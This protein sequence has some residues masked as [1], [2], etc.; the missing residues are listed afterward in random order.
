MRMWKKVLAAGVSAVMIFPAATGAAV[1]NGEVHA[2]KQASEQVPITA[3]A[4]EKNK[5]AYKKLKEM[6]EL[7]DTDT[8]VIKYSKPLGKSVHKK[9]G[10]T[11]VRSL[12]QLGYDVVRVPKSKKVSE[13]VKV[14]RQQKGVSSI[15]PSVKYKQFAAQGDPKKSKMHHLPMLNID[16]SLKLAGKHKV[17]VAVVDGGV[18][19]KHPDLQ[20]QLLP[21]YNAANPASNPIR[22]MHGTHVAGIIASKANN[23]IGGHGVNP[24]AKILPVDVFNGKMSANDFTI[25]EGILYAV[26]KGAD[27][28]N[29]SL[30]G[31]ASSPLVEEAVR[32]AIDSGVVVVAAAGNEATD[33]YS[34]PAAYPGVISVGNIDRN[35]KLS[36]SSNFGPSV[37][38]VAPGE[39]IYNTGYEKDGK[40]SSFASLTGTSMAAPMV[41][42]VASLLKSKYPQLTAYDIENILERTA[43]DL[44]AK[45]YDTKY[46]NG[47]VNP[48]AAL[49][50][51]IKKLPKQP[52]LTGDTLIRSA[53]PLKAGKNTLKGQIKT[54]GETHWFKVDLNENE[55]VQTI[56]EGSSDYDYGMDFYFIPE[57]A[58]SEEGMLME[59]NKG[60]AGEQEGSLFTAEEKGT[61]VIGVKD[62]NGN[63]NASGLSAYTFT[64][65]KITGLKADPD[66]S[67]NPVKITSLPYKKGDFTLFPQEAGAPD[68]DH[69]TIAVDE[70]KVVS[71]SLSALPGVNSAM[72]LSVVTQDEKERTEEIVAEADDHGSSQGES[73]SFKAVP[74][75]EYKLV[76]TNEAF[77][78]ME[79]MG[80]LLDM[81]TMNPGDMEFGDYTASAYPYELKVEEKQLPED[82][83]G[84]P[85]KEDLETALEEGSLSPDKYAEAKAAAA[86][87]GTID[88]EEPSEEMDDA[89]TKA[90]LANA[91]PYT[92]GKELSGY[93]QVEA[94]EDYYSFTPAQNGVYEFDVQ[95]GS[96]QFPVVSILQHDKETGELIPISGGEDDM[97][98]SIMAMLGGKQTSQTT[99]ALKKGETYI[100][101]LANEMYNISADPYTLRS[102]KVADTPKEADQDQSVPEKARVMKSGGAYKNYFIYPGET[103]FYYFKNGNKQDVYRL[104]IDQAKLAAA[105]KALPYALR[106]PA[107][108]AGALIEDT[109]GNKVIDEDEQLKAIP[110]GPNLFELSFETTANLSF[111]A[112]KDTGYFLAVSSLMSMKPSLQPYEVKLA[113]MKDAL[114]DG[115]GKVV[116]HV[117]QKP[118]SLKKIDGQLGARGYINA[119]VP[120]GDVDHFALNVTKD[121]QFSLKLEMEPGLDGKI[122]IYNA[123]GALVRSFD[124][125]GSGDEE[126]AVIQLK[127]G[128]YFIEISE[129]EGR[130]SAQPYKLTVR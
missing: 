112:K 47:L 75:V 60:R 65:E 31:F 20:G 46:A 12:P 105:E 69:F 124:H 41:A 118:L 17:T 7:I 127:K 92:L 80:S 2:I 79:G 74:G 5:E 61:L 106:Q 3:A 126:L 6:N 22:D 113:D 87:D 54:P 36:D 100:L 25:A 76:V 8:L 57:G 48:L 18:D 81:L 50:Y 4:S 38:V 125:Y 102:K 11:L 23:G 55:H 115:D 73:L 111:M 90:I 30:G 37:D 34:Y 43:T 86:L 98:G 32:E 103:D 110:F 14:Y 117:P 40:G 52:V 70:A 26:S 88:E 45:G 64:A 28:I 129:I 109:N 72:R 128:K 27:V 24:N 56:L 44:G 39:D 33:M 9:A 94:D 85:F 49:S 63:Y 59:H 91:R 19:Y 114:K 123:K 1:H 13:A 77:G 84:L 21:P 107:I 67:E 93:F 68:Y 71:I 116:N 82:E 97:L 95:K 16:K 78:G 104:N 89:L 120:F 51:D 42:G 101:R 53:K 96:S 15:T 83:D 58:E 108:F 35:K 99:I 29:L 130:A 119:G 66:T 10:T 122:E 121:R 62:V